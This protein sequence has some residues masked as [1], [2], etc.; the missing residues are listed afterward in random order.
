MIDRYKQQ[1]I[2][3]MAF[4]S[5]F[6]DFKHK[7]RRFSK[8]QR[9]AAFSNKKGKKSSYGIFNQLDQTATSLNNMIKKFPYNCRKFK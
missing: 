1:T 3:E 8:S 5:V 7:R 2:L 9:L 6:N 4:H